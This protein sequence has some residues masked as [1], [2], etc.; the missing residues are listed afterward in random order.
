VPNFPERFM[1]KKNKNGGIFATA[2]RKDAKDRKKIKMG[3]Y[4][5]RCGR[6]KGLW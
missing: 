6:Y 5:Y 2:K 4:C 3:R 1:K